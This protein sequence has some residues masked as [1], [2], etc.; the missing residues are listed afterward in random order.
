MFN[1]LS[2]YSESPLVTENEFLH[3]SDASHVS[4]L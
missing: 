3:W 1:S 2:E 4:Y